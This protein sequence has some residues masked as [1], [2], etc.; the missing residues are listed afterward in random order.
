M[1]RIESGKLWVGSESGKL[2]VGSE[3]GKLW[4]GSESGKVRVGSRI[5][6]NRSASFSVCLEFDEHIFAH[7]PKYSTGIT[8]TE[9]PICGKKY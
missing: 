3:P 8:N 4:V 9:C 7:V 6:L 1:G 2:W 5:S